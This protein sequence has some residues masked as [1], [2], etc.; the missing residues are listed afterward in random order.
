[1]SNRNK[2]LKSA[3]DLTNKE[4]QENLLYVLDIFPGLYCRRVKAG[5]SPPVSTISQPVLLIAFATNGTHAYTRRGLSEPVDSGTV[6]QNR[7]PSS[8]EP[9]LKDRGFIQTAG[10]YLGWS[11]QR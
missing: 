1:M 11:D 5:D 7:K 9:Y 10:R 4:Q 8:A 3:T 6:N 2:P